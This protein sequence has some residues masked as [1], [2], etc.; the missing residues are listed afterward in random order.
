MFLA[1]LFVVA[2][3]GIAGA[4]LHYRQERLLGHQERMRALELGREIPETRRARE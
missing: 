3:V 4:F 1:G 2:L